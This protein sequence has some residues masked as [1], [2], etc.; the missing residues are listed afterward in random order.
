M[1]EYCSEVDKSLTLDLATNVLMY[2]SRRFLRVE[3]GEKI[4]RY[5]MIVASMPRNSV[6]FR[7][8]YAL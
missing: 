4:E 2:I 5:N 8:L 1:L 7:Q 6:C 3:L